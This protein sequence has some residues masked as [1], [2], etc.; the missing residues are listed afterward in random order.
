M[1]VNDSPFQV[2]LDELRQVERRN[3]FSSDAMVEQHRYFVQD[4]RAEDRKVG[5]LMKSLEAL[6]AAANS[7]LR[8]QRRT[9]FRQKLAQAGELLEE[10]IAAGRVSAVDA[11]KAEA[12]LARLAAT[13]GM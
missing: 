3:P 2:L 5:D 12:L 11:A 7:D 4:C 9:E 8:E 1:N 10:A 13:V 6:H